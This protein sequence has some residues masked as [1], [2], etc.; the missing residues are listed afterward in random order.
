MF[1]IKK[2]TI[3]TLSVAALSLYAKTDKYRLTWREDKTATTMVVGWNQIDGDNATV[4]YGTKDLGKDWEKYPLKNGVDNSIE[5]APLN[6]KF[7]RLKNLK[8]DTAYYFVI[9]DSNSVSER[10]WFKTAPDKPQ[11]IKFIAGG[12]SR[13]SSKALTIGNQTVAKIRPLFIVFGGD[14]TGSGSAKQWVK[15]LDNWQ[16]TISEDGRMYPV[17]PTEGNH[18]KAPGLIAMFDIEN[19]QIYSSISFGGNMTRLWA[20]NTQ[21]YK[22]KRIE[23]FKEQTAWFLNDIAENNNYKWKMAAYHRPMRP[24]AA[25][26]DEGDL[27]IDA[28]ADAFYKY[29]MSLVFESDTHMVKRTYPIRPSK[30]EGNDEGFVRD[31]KNGIV[32]IGEGSWAAPKRPANDNKSWTRASD[33]FYQFKLI[34][35]TPEKIESRVVMLEH[36]KNVMPLKESDP[37]FKLPDGIKIWKPET[38]AV[39]T[40][41]FEK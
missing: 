3:S 21:L 14:F 24:H 29:R 41:P 30:K 12:D 9:K 26:K 28:W 19:P 5:L 1:N 4:Y 37:L 31:D 27:Y 23:K 39:L 32:F 7:A 15:W 22:G 25:H 6:N 33:S 10:Y 11:P 8:P 38:G 40:I 36:A 13:G 34:H 2:I 20:L 16:N 35:M 17:I 18:D